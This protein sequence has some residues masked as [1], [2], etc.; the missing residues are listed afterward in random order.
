MAKWFK[1]FVLFLV[2]SV[3]LAGT[4]YFCVCLKDKMVAETRIEGFKVG[5]AYTIRKI[6]GMVGD[7]NPSWEAAKHILL[8]GACGVH[9]EGNGDGE[10]TV[11]EVVH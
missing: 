3:A 2:I 8:R 4:A 9:I 6:D 7:E 10:F 5:V 1:N 11:S